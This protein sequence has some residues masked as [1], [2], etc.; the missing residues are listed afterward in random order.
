MH[1]YKSLSNMIDPAIPHRTKIERYAAATVAR[2]TR[3]AYESAWRQ[4]V[5]WC[6]KHR[7]SPLPAKPAAVASYIVELAELGRAVSTINKHLQA[8]GAYHLAAGEE[9]SP[10]ATLLV[11]Q[12]RAGIRRDLGVAPRNR[13]DPLL[14]EDIRAI[15]ARIPDS[16]KGKRDRA[17]ILIG[18]AG[19]YRRSEIVAL[20]V[21]DIQDHPSGLVLTRRHGKDD[22]LGAGL[23]KGIPYGTNKETC[24]V[25]ALR[26]WLAASGITSGPVFRGMRGGRLGDRRLGGG[27]VA[28]II[29]AACE[30]AG[31][32]SRRFAGHSLRAGLATAAARE[33][34]GEREIMKQTGHRSSVVRQYIREGELFKNNPAARVGL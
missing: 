12:T 34:V 15:C 25:R 30:A 27:E 31:Y 7:Q 19:A 16:L 13:K 17:V 11:R 23:R 9:Y 26:A 1:G 20:D 21:E 14:T 4:F 6:E 22:Q 3:Q 10:T 5:A 28:R 2:S 8:I 33:G 32:D 29:K 24:P 18:F